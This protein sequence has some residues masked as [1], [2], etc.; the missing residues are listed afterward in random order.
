MHSGHVG[1][2][3]RVNVS[4]KRILEKR[5]EAGGCGSRRDELEAAGVEAGEGKVPFHFNT[6][7]ENEEVLKTYARSTLSHF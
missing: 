6:V 7:Q 1:H 2:I 5:V 3:L 4:V